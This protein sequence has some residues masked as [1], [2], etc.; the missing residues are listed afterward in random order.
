MT[1]HITRISRQR[2]VPS[3]SVVIELPS[4]LELAKDLYCCVFDSLY[5]PGACSTLKPAL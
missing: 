2:P 3:S 4:W 1:T 5:G